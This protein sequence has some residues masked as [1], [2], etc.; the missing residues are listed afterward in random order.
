MSLTEE[1][2]KDM[3]YSFRIVDLHMLLADFSINLPD[4]KSQLR[5]QALELLRNKS[6]CIN[7]R[8]FKD[9]I[10]ETYRL[11]LT[12]SHTNNKRRSTLENN[13][14]KIMSIG[15]PLPN[16]F[17]LNQQS[18][19]NPQQFINILPPPRIQKVVN[20]NIFSRSNNFQYDY[21]PIDPR[22]VVTP[23]VSNQQGKTVAVDNSTYMNSTNSFIPSI[24]SL[25]NVRLK[26]LPFYEDVAE[27]IKLSTLIGRG[28]CSISNIHEGIDLNCI[29]IFIC[30]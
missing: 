4:D 17:K 10:N 7:Y 5:N 24:Q 1:N 14:Q 23:V 15:K 26:K 11:M 30:V 6:A 18:T 20:R 25:A 19:Q 21:I 8:A 2:Y 12:E 28:N 27:V 16:F 29:F 3:I 22:Y 9:K 13:N